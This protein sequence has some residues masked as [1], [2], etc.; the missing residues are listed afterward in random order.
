MRERTTWTNT[1]I[2]AKAAALSE[3]TA[4]DPRAM[5]QDHHSQQPAADAYD[6]G[7]P[8]EFAE[9]PHPSSQWKADDKGGETARNEIGMPE[10]RGDTFNHP[11]KTASDEDEATLL[12]KADLCADIA[13]KMFPTASEQVVE[14]Q[15]FSLMHL[16]TEELI[17]TSNRLAGLVEAKK[18]QEQEEEEEEQ[19]GQQQGQ[20]QGQQGQ[21]Q[22]QQQGKQ[23]GQVPPQFLKKDDEKKD[24][25]GK[26]EAGQQQ[27]SQQQQQAQDDE[28]EGQ[29][30]EKE[31]S[32]RIAAA[33]QANDQQALQAAIQDMVQQAF[34]QGQMAQQQQMAQQDQQM[35]Q[36]Q[37]QAQ[38]Q[39]QM[40]SMDQVQA[41]IQQALQQQMAQQQ[42]QGQQQQMSDDQLL[43]QMLM[44]DAQ[45]G[46]MASAS[47]A[48]GTTT[49]AGEIAETDIQ[50]EGAEMDVG[51]VV[52]GAEDAALQGLFMASEEYQNAAQAQELTTGVPAPQPSTPVQ[53][54][55]A[56]TASTRT[57]GTRPTQ[58]VSQLGGAAAGSPSGGGEVDKLS[59]LW[60]SAPDVTSV[61]R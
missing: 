10:F 53:A 11:E 1:D 43:D 39:Q 12:K 52:L 37:Q 41:M 34:A 13:K 28:K 54:G 29:Q 57:V 6:I 2:L 30:Q 17:A 45:Q 8:S 49:T 16:P 35:A 48:T 21:G 60:Q 46:V 61:F 50:L 3:R 59:G 24:D 15:S 18:G 4:E 23:G 27:Q 19:G 32:A 14:D 31:A 38:G 20:G 51:E 7:G 9:D 55:T 5:N 42:Q 56:R 40:M 47:E 25:E 44:D 58:G 33:I 26:K 36:Q 22:G